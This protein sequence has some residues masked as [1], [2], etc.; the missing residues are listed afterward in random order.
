MNIVR[1]TF[2][3]LL[4]FLVAHQAV[5]GQQTLVYVKVNEE[6]PCPANSTEC[7]TLRWYTN[8]STSSFVSNTMMLFQEGMHVLDVLILFK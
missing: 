2:L 6:S 7:Q 4:Q 1:N 3:L 5:L 8:R